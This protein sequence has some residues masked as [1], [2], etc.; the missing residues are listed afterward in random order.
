MNIVRKILKSKLQILNAKYANDLVV[1]FTENGELFVNT[2][3]GNHLKVSDT[4]IVPEGNTTDSI[5]NPDASKLYIVSNRDV[6]TSKVKA[7]MYVY[8]ETNNEFVHLFSD[9]YITI[10]NIITSINNINTVLNDTNKKDKACISA[11]NLTNI[12]LQ[13]YIVIDQFGED[14]YPAIQLDE[15]N[16]ITNA[17]PVSDIEF[18]LMHI[19]NN[20]S[21][22]IIT[23]CVLNAGEKTN[24][25]V[26][27]ESDTYKF[28]NGQIYAKIN[29]DGNNHSN[30]NIIIS[31]HSFK[32]AS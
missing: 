13:P 32:A 16:I 10:T 18:D 1:S 6:D 4:G 17:A 7:N 20:G 8:D 14:E 5:E 21:E 24:K 25:I 22:S 28:Y 26:L 12:A 30:I 27:E 2:K 31:M 11:Y 9:A 19:N 3:D 15:I 29:K 23:N